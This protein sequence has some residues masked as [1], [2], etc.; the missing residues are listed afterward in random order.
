MKQ[1]RRVCKTTAKLSKST[2]LQ[3][4]MY[5]LAASAAGVGVLALAQPAEGKIVYTP[6]NKQIGPH[7]EVQLDLNHDDIVD[8][9]LSN[10]VSCGTD[11]CF[12]DFLQ[13]PASG[14]SAVGYVLDG[15]L[16]LASALKSGARIGSGAAFK[17]GTAGLVEI[18]FSF[19]G[20]STNDFGRWRNVKKRYL[21]LQF[22]ILGQA[23]Y[24]W[25]RLN[26]EV[27]KTTITGTLTGY[28]YETVPNK[29]IIAGKTKGK[30]V[31]YAAPAS[32]GALAAGASGL[33]A[34]RKQ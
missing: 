20:Q 29:P 4:E 27:K 34:W 22:Q 33:R 30:D 26:V 3:L 1:S 17:P 2:H 31:M 28:A 18:V 21:G 7:Q 25:A 6:T 9:T 5:A 19:G 8:F 12:Y 13:I 32:L 11:I 16:L 24:G 14:N 10:V 23:H 15:Q